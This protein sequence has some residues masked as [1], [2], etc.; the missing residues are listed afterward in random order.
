LVPGE[1]VWDW[2]EVPGEN[3]EVLPTSDTSGCRE[4]LVAI[5]ADGGGFLR[6][7]T[8]LLPERERLSGLRDLLG[9]QMS[10]L[11]FE[12]LTPAFHVDVAMR[13][14][15]GLG[16]AVIDHSLMRVSRTREL[17]ADGEDTLVL[18]IPAGGG[19]ASQLGREVTLE[20]GDAVLASS[21][22]VGTFTCTSAT[23][24]SLVLSLPRRELLPLVADFDA[25]L[26]TRVPGGT[27]AL[28]L[29]T[30]YLDIFEE[31]EVPAHE[32]AHVAVTHVY[33][34]A[35]LALG[36]TADAVEIV[37]RRG[38]R[39]ARLREAMTFAKRNA[40]RQELS[41]AMVA[42]HLGVTPRYIHMLF[43]NESE[44]F[45][46]FLLRARLARARR[47]LVDPRFAD[48][49][50]STIAFDSGF[51]DLSHFNRSFRRRFGMTPSQARGE[52]R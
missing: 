49:P 35:A 52:P 23:G 7:S 27:A 15:H 24:K 4:N 25:A 5:P 48:R 36:A 41:A 51:R 33:D 43:E 30:R 37:S 11:D 9:R 16:I 14:V 42:T 26:M 8:G 1:I 38:V 34:L 3:R 28:Q 31:M 29:L 12:P 45:S 17:L 18:Q 6:F 32:L 47:M 21:A 13:R 2:R 19:V 46:E 22:D 44:S 39:A 20:P 10:R 50:I 40:A